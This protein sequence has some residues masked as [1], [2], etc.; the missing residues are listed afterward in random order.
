MSEETIQEEARI[1]AQRAFE[2]ERRVTQVL[3]RPLRELPAVASIITCNRHDTV[4]QAIETMQQQRIGCLLVVDQ[5]RLVGIFTER[6]VL[7]KTAARSL[8]IAHTPVEEL[9]TTNPECLGLDDEIVYA[10]NQM[11][12]GG[13]RHIPLVDS[14]GRPTG[15]VSMRDLVG[16][17]V[18][19]FPQDV[20]NIPPSPQ[21][22]LPS[23]R[24]GA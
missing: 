10:L 11:S 16:V 6:D 14:E 18:E 8:D 23:S 15:V 5:G 1:A 12:V 3:R 22:G 17:L 21:H 9:M 19:V 7:M 4:Q 20:L 13:Y 2:E 24:E